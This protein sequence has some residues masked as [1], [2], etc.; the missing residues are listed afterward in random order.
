MI[1]RAAERR[2]ADRLPDSIYIDANFLITVL[3]SGAEYHDE[4]LRFAE[5][6]VNETVP[7][8]YSELTLIEF[9]NGWAKLPHRDWFPQELREGLG[10]HDWSN[11]L[12]RLRWMDYGKQC[13]LGFLG[14]FDKFEIR[15]LK[16]IKAKMLETMADFNLR[17]N[18]ALHICTM[19]HLGLV[20]LTSL[21][22]DFRCVIGIH[23]WNDCK[24]VRKR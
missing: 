12:V 11:Q 17:S 20:D 10:L 7:L 3:V 24:F 4:C 13:L 16:P 18:D 15:L 5:R 22:E 2:F 6:L 23:L 8:F 9:Y 1:V 21:D 14:Q 19:R